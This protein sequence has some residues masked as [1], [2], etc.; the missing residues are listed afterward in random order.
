[1][2]QHEAN[3]VKKELEIDDLLESVATELERDS[4]AVKESIAKQGKSIFIKLDTKVQKN[5][6]YYQ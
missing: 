6:R 2:S 4:Q 1:M 5:L 3:T